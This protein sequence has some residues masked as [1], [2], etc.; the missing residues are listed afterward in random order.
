[1]NMTSDMRAVL[2]TCLLVI[3]A[4]GLGVAGKGLLDDTYSPIIFGVLLC[5]SMGSYGI[6]SA[7]KRWT[8][9]DTKWLVLFAVSIPG[10]IAMYFAWVA[11]GL[12]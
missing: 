1:M 11:G 12:T 3:V 2:I 4:A 7:H 10:L 8:D 6:L 5:L 9:R